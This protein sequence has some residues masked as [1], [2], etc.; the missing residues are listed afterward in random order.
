MATLVVGAFP[1]PVQ[2]VSCGVEGV[3]LPMARSI[4]CKHACGLA[5]A[6]RSV[7]RHKKTNRESGDNIKLLLTE[8]KQQVVQGEYLRAEVQLRRGGVPNGFPLAR[9][10]HSRL[11]RCRVD[12]GTKISNDGIR[13]KNNLPPSIHSFHPIIH[14]SI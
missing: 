10:A 9:G 1:A 6:V 8:S 13:R 14:S 4:D 5:Y 2:R 12:R 11:A 3:R 7:A